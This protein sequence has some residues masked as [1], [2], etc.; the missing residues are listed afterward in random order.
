MSLRHSFRPSSTTCEYMC[1]DFSA[2]AAFPGLCHVHKSPTKP[3][4]AE[5]SRSRHTSLGRKEP[6]RCVTLRRV[7]KAKFGLPYRPA[8][9]LDFLRAGGV[10]STNDLARGKRALWSRS[11]TVGP[12]K[13]ELGLSQAFAFPPSRPALTGAG[14]G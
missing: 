6:S 10:P 14:P 11:P 9:I 4:Q 13:S 5:G 7:S 1:R 2:S 12:K 3:K 8:L